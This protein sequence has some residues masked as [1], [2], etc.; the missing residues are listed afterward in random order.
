M[1]RQVPK[2]VEHHRERGPVCGSRGDRGAIYADDRQESDEQDDSRDGGQPLRPSH[3][4]RV[5]PAPEQ[6]TDDLPAGQED[7]TRGQDP[8]QR[9]GCA[10]TSAENERDQPVCDQRERYQHGG[11][12]SYAGQDGLALHSPRC[13]G[14]GLLGRQ[15][16]EGD[17]AD[18]CDERHGQRR[19]RYGY[20]VPAKV[21][22]R[23]GLRQHELVKLGVQGSGRQ[24]RYL[25]DAVRRDRTKHRNTSVAGC[26]RVLP[27]VP[28][29]PPKLQRQCGSQDVQGV[30]NRE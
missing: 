8:Q 19:E 17:V 23:D 25:S 29:A 18:G 22:G 27:A 11:G 2:R 5:I 6:V 14:D 15:P 16:R 20:R 12:D 10:V 30:I 28:V 9:D 21:S 1:T 7:R 4:G 26:Q 24:C 13:V 3:D